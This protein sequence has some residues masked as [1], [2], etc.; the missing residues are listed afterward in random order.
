MQRQT[1][2]I[3]SPAGY[4][5]RLIQTAKHGSGNQGTLAPG[6]DAF[7]SFLS[8]GVRKLM[9]EIFHPIIDRAVYEDRP[10]M[11]LL[12][13]L[14]ERQIVA[15]LEKYRSTLVLRGRSSIQNPCGYLV[16]QLKQVSQEQGAQCGDMNASKSTI[17][18]LL[19][20]GGNWGQ[21]V[22]L[23]SLKLIYKE[24]N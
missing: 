14:P 8:P 3:K 17:I 21:Q 9:L 5:T 1:N 20:S 13:K 6:E 15:A 12:A 19:T 24:C 4:L 18:P 22:R 16:H 7:V 2:K 11:G 23:C 10:L